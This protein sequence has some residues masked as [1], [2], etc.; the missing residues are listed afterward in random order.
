MTNMAIRILLIS[1]AAFLL[2]AGVIVMI[3]SRATNPVGTSLCL[4]A[5]VIGILYTVFSER[6]KRNRAKSATPK[7]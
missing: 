6:S 1:V 4:A 3:V 7:A 5:A 2:L